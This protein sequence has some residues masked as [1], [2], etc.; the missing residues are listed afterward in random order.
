MQIR[1]RNGLTEKLLRLLANTME[2]MQ[3]GQTGRCHV[4]RYDQCL[5]LLRDALQVRKNG[6]FGTFLL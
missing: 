2:A 6:A 1:P 4:I 5:R 3:I